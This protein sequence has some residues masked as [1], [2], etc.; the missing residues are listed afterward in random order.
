MVSTSVGVWALAVDDARVYWSVYVPYTGFVASAPKSGGASTMLATGLDQPAGV[1]V[2][3]ES[4]YVAMQGTGVPGSILKVPKGGGPAATSRATSRGR[5]TSPST[6]PACTG[7]M[8]TA[9]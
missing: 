7:R 6:T 1:A 5:R 2:D 4:L 8:V 3:A 9:P